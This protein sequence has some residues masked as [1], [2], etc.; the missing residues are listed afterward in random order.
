LPF[1]EKENLMT[2]PVARLEFLA[3]E[4]MTTFFNPE[5]GDG[6]FL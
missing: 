1:L 2:L 6:M 3:A 5:G 4:L